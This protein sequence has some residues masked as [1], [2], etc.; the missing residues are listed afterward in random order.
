[1]IALFVVCPSTRG[2]G[3]EA[4]LGADYSLPG[5]DNPAFIL[6]IALAGSNIF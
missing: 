3:A 5:I 1:M 4:I 2:D 6:P